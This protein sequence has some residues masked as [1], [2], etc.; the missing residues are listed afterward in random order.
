MLLRAHGVAVLGQGEAL[1]GAAAAD[2][3]QVDAQHAA[4]DEQHLLDRRQVAHRLQHA[5][6]RGRRAREQECRLR[7]ATVNDVIITYQIWLR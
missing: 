5:H 4:R 2:V 6:V 7:R 3:Q 1:R